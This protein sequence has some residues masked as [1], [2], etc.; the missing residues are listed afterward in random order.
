MLLQNPY[1][2]PVLLLAVSAG[3]LAGNLNNVSE[4][5]RKILQLWRGEKTV[6]GEKNVSRETL[7]NTNRLPA[8][9]NSEGL[10]AES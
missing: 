4:F 6:F 9:G 1:S 2:N 7:N 5:S 8:G 3:I 10:G